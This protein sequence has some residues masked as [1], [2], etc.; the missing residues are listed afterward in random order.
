MTL[1]LIGVGWGRGNDCVC[2]WLLIKPL[3]VWGED[4]GRETNQVMQHERREGVRVGECSWVL[5]KH[6]I[7]TATRSILQTRS[8]YWRVA[9][10]FYDGLHG[11]FAGKSMPHPDAW[12]QN[13]SVL[14]HVTYSSGSTYE[15]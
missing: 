10:S 3:P 4:R 15:D 12:G 13:L 1:G 7:V 5:R 2:F 6:G 9:S 14:F 8:D 11:L